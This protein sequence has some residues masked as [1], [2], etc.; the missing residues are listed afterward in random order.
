MSIIEKYNIANYQNPI[1]EYQGNFQTN[2]PIEAYPKLRPDVVNTRKP[3][4]KKERA[5][6]KR[7]QKTIQK[8]FNSI[9]CHP[10][11]IK[12]TTNGFENLKSDLFLAS[13][14]GG[15]QQGFSFMDV[16]EDWEQNKESVMPDGSD[17][18]DAEVSDMGIPF[19]D[20]KISEYIN[21]YLDKVNSS[22]FYHR[23][24]KDIQKALSNV[25]VY[26]VFNSRNQI[27]IEKDEFTF[28]DEKREKFQEP[29][30]P[31]KKKWKFTTA[32]KFQKGDEANL[33]Q[34]PKQLIYD[35][36]GGFDPR[37]ETINPQTGYFFFNYK[38]AKRYLKRV[39]NTHRYWYKSTLQ[40]KPYTGYSL[41][42]LG[43][44]SAY[45]I[46]RESHP[47]IDFR[48]IPNLTE[49][50]KFLTEHVGDSNVIVDA[51]QQ[52][53]RVRRRAK[54]L[55]PALGKWGYKGSPTSSF[56]QRNEYFKGVPIYIV[57]VSET[58]RSLLKERYFT[59]VNLL[60]TFYGKIINVLDSR[61]GFGQNWIMQG[62]LD[63]SQKS[64]E[65]TNVIFFEKGEADKFVK[66]QGRKIIRQRGSRTSNLE[67]IIQKPKI[68]VSN[69][70]DFLESWEDKIHADITNQSSEKTI[71]DAKSTF[72]V[73]AYQQEAIKPEDAKSSNQFIRGNFDRGRVRVQKMSKWFRSLFRAY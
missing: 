15:L 22:N 37:K 2:N 71:L 45:R 10:S 1:I 31:Y 3:V 5:L 48:L 25:P 8:G 62:S 6:D 21:G 47:G 44:D 41:H 33:E 12:I 24:T 53:L 65:V 59:V 29:K 35:S 30:P 60:D 4:K 11:K 34:N 17:E 67:S 58:S 7:R 49:V 20:Y 32:F 13:N 69:L 64:D 51:G 16:L 66:E 46:M 63:D 70:E 54:N 26:V 73:P 72:F 18:I 19:T 57:Q 40:R 42:C 61:L 27:A 56:L 14:Y 50:N 23:K 39:T 9:Y 43:L 28:F 55:F 38:D 52:Q 68:F 36:A